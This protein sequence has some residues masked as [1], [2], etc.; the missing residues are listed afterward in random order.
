MLAVDQLGP[1]YLEA[2][3]QE[4]ADLQMLEFSSSS[5]HQSYESRRP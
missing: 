3:P 1:L 5:C 4:L 2:M